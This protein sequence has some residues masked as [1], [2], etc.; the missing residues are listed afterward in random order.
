MTSAV[1]FASSSCA[2]CTVPKARRRAKKEL[3]V[4]ADMVAVA[5]PM[6]AEEERVKFFSGEEENYE[7]QFMYRLPPCVLEKA[8]RQYSL[9]NQVDRRFVPHAKRV[10]N[11]LLQRYGSYAAYQ[12][13]YGGEALS[14]EE[15]RPI[16]DEYLA[17]LGVQDEIRVNFDPNLVA[18]ASFVK[19]AMVLNIR[20]Q[21][22]RK[23]WIEGMLHHEIGTHFLRDRNDKYQPWSREKNGR[24]RYRLEDKN[25]TEEGLASLH[26]V[27]E[28][29][30][31]CLWRPALLYY[32]TWR[33]LELSFRDL[34][35][36][37]AQFL[38]NST[39][40]RWDYCVR[41]KRGLLDTSQPGGL[42]KDQA[43]LAGAMEILEQRRRI[44]FTSLY[45]GKL[46]V[47]DSHRCRSTGLARLDKILLPT[48]LQGAEQKARY[49]ELLD[50][51]VR[52][53]GLSD[54]LDGGGTANQQLPAAS[55]S[56]GRPKSW[57]GGPSSSSGGGGSLALTLPAMR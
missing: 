38:G 15:A 43:Y 31:H 52:E 46:S 23:N 53:N 48:F 37:L 16:V 18:R 8:L 33:A 56:A 6:N 12:E 44:D 32:A 5:R 25:P 47:L 35:E 28:R 17:K 3:K 29:E 30:G 54:L 14:I 20:P 26:T 34:Y 41:A 13:Q 24:K 19:R 11:T 49:M 7:P 10:L 39:D 2:C 21:G 50:E 51:T 57:N 40:E 36:D 1:R 9:D 45:A 4:P 42:A 27:L 55:S 22:L